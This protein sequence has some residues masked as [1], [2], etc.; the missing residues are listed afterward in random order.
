M[1]V[2]VKIFDHFMLGVKGSRFQYRIPDF[3]AHGLIV[4]ASSERTIAA[5]LIVFFEENESTVQVRHTDVEICAR[6]FPLE[7]ELRRRAA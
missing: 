6:Q 5:H 4:I 3:P 2:A 1:P 7:V